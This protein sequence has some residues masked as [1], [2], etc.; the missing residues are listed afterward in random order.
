MNINNFCDVQG[1]AHTDRFLLN[2]RHSKADLSYDD[3]YELLKF[4]FNLGDKKE[5]SI[6]TNTEQK[7]EIALG[8]KEVI[9]EKKA[10]KKETEKK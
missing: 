2:K 3:W 9:E 4:D 5:L 6:E 10:T 7:E 8:E 1:I